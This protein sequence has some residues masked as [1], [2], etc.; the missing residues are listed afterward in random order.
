MASVLLC[1][2]ACCVVLFLL[3]VLWSVAF[4]YVKVLSSCVFFVC[5]LCPDYSHLVM[6][7]LPLT[8]CSVSLLGLH[9]DVCLVFFKVVFSLNPDFA[10]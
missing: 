2:C 1:H 6:I 10:V 8:L 4:F 3:P 7:N 5:W 9:P